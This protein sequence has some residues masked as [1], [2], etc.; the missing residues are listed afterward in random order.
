MRQTIEDCLRENMDVDGFLTVNADTSMITN[1]V[2][3]PLHT[4]YAGSDPVGALRDLSI[5]VAVEFEST[6]GGTSVLTPVPASAHTWNTLD[7]VVALDWL[8][9]YTL[10]LPTSGRT[11]ADADGIWFHFEVVQDAPGALTPFEWSVDTGLNSLSVDNTSNLQRLIV[12]TLA[13]G[14]DPSSD[15]TLDVSTVDGLGDEIR[16]L[17]MPTAPSLVLR[18]GLPDV[19]W[20]H[21]SLTETLTISEADGG[22]HQWWVVAN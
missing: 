1:L 9:Q 12:D 21:D 15:I 14:L 20:V 4:W 22:A 19:N 5:T 2:H 3:V 17:N 11:L 7:E 6:F 16:F 13:L 18:D 10:N 8:E